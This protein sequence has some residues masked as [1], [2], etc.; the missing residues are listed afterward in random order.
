MATS[1]LITLITLLFGLLQTICIGIIV[2]IFKKIEQSNKETN[3]KFL[4]INSRLEDNIKEIYHD[5]FS[6]RHTDGDSEVY[7][8]GKFQ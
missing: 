1:L 6:H 4:L 3:E 2:Y 7:I 5:V 8:P